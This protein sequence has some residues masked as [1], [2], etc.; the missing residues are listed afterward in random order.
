MV[1]LYHVPYLQIL[2]RDQVV[3]PD[4]PVRQFVQEV[5]PLPG[6]LQV[7]GAKPGHGLPAVVAALLLSGNGALQDP[8]F[9]LSGPIPFRI[10]GL[11]SIAVGNEAFDADIEAGDLPGCRQVLCR[12]LTGNQPLTAKEYSAARKRFAEEKELAQNLAK[13]REVRAEKLKVKKAPA[14]TKAAKPLPVK[15]VAPAKDVKAK[16]VKAKAAVKPTK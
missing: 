14:A 2:Q 7:M 12:S 1:I 3:L 16:A 9:L 8:K 11:Y 13:A 10:L 15:K 4:Q 6:D 5:L